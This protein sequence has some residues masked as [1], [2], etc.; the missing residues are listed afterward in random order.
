M[1]CD[2]TNER[3]ATGG[4]GQRVKRD[5]E[6]RGQLLELLPPAMLFRRQAAQAALNVLCVDGVLQTLQFALEST[7]AGVVAL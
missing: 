5:V 6:T 1:G 7:R 4:D 3:H 2:L